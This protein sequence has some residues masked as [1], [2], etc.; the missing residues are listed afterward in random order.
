VPGGAVILHLE[1]DPPETVKNAC[2]FQGILDEFNQAAIEAAHKWRFKPAQH[3]S[4]KA[5]D[6][7]AYA[8]CVYRP[9]PN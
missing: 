1:I 5:C 8:V 4:G 9:L 7:Q 3:E 6:S 2:I